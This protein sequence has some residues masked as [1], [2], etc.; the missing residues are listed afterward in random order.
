MNFSQE[1]NIC[2]KE[3]R[4]IKERR[5]EKVWIYES[6]DTVLRIGTAKEID[7]EIEQQVNFSGKA[8]QYQISSHKV[9]M[10][11]INISSKRKWGNS[12]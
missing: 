8:S 7:G 3:W 6:N 10:K 5:Y 12:Q 9:L 4:L 11:H 1:V 2:G